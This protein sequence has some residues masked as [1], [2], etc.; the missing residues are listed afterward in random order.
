M[1]VSENLAL[2]SMHKKIEHSPNKK[3]KN[4]KHNIWLYLFTC[5]LWKQFLELKTVFHIICQ[6]HSPTSPTN[7]LHAT[8]G[9]QQFQ[10][11][12]SFPFQDE[13]VALVK[14][15]FGLLFFSMKHWLFFMK[16][17]SCF[18][19]N[20]SLEGRI[21]AEFRTCHCMFSF[22]K[23][24]KLMPSFQEKEKKKSFFF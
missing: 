20:I 10:R 4:K 8:E 14:K 23:R 9:Y 5:F 24:I 17:S 1:E 22:A 16:I 21:I 15:V 13:E 12:P 2:L 7:T 6:F 18:S 19:A 3:K 11:A